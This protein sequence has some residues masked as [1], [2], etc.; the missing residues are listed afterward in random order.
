ML[1]LLSV[2]WDF[3]IPV[4]LND[5]KQMFLYD[6]GHRDS[7]KLFLEDL[8]YHR[9]ATFQA[10]GLPLPDTSGEEI[11]FWDRFDFAPGA[12][13]FF[14]DSHVRAFSPEVSQDVITVVNFD[15]HHDGG[16]NT[17]LNAI[18]KADQ[19]DCSSWMAGYHM[20]GAMVQTIYPRWKAWAKQVEAKPAIP[21]MARRV[22]G[23]KNMPKRFMPFDRVFVCRSGGW[24]P[25][26]LDPK[27]DQF[28]K[29]C[30]LEKK[31]DIGL[32]ERT[33]DPAILQAQ[34]DAWKRFKV[35]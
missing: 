19:V 18:R 6:W 8:W 5:P 24:S 4:A 33:F 35:V 12:Q 2:D 30:P 15:A 28:L 9:G 31:I 32:V 3:F 13:L 14:A 16:Y 21:K 23:D 7:G 11:G 10:N 25:S 26:W 29:D 34:T 1:N 17:T 27:F 20:C 22:D